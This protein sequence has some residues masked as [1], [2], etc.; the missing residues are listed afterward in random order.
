MTHISVQRFAEIAKCQI[1]T[2][3]LDALWN[4]IVNGKP[5]YVTENLLAELNIKP[6][7]QA[8]FISTLIES[9]DYIIMND[10]KYLESRTQ[11]ITNVNDIDR[12]YPVTNKSTHV[13]LAANRVQDVAMR[14]NNS[15][16]VTDYYHAPSRSSI[17][18]IFDLYQQYLTMSNA[19][20]TGHVYIA[21]TVEYEKNNIYTFGASKVM[22]RKLK[23]LNEV[24]PTD[25]YRYIFTA[26][27][28]DAAGIEKKLLRD[29]AACKL[30]SSDKTYKIY[31]DRLMQHMIHYVRADQ[32][33]VIFRNV[34]MVLDMYC[35]ET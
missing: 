27:V 8:Q 29:F 30:A 35:R 26:A 16:F 18:L 33:E 19:I 7:F 23:K 3:Y 17:K 6:C 9:T 28:S 22:E 11:M 24:R 32:D 5:L 2:Q 1:E 31:H 4:T 21:T 14:I 15:N 13:V 34:M 12:V 20:T 10:D 25:Q